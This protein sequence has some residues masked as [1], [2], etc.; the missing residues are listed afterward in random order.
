VNRQSKRLMARQQS[1]SE[2]ERAN[3]PKKVISQKNQPESKRL[4][5]KIYLREVRDEL[6]KVTWP[7]RKTVI[8]YSTV[9]FITLTFLIALI[10]VLN[11][12]FSKAVLFLFG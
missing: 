10:F 8:N 7:T 6:K 11:L 5:P 2:A 12:A 1:Q 3:A 9:V 4:T